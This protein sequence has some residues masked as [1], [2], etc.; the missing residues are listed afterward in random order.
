M[1]EKLSN[2]D[3]E[4]DFIIITNLFNVNIKFTIKIISK[5]TSLD[6]NKANRCQLEKCNKTKLKK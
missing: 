5:N 2:K 1:T 6:K 4:N 3:A